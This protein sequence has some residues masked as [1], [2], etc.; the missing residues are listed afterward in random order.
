MG[1]KRT[2][3]CYQPGEEVAVLQPMLLLLA[4]LAA[5]NAAPTAPS[6][7]VVQG[8]PLLVLPGEARRYRGQ[9]GREGDITELLATSEQT[10][11]KLGIF[12]QTI[13][14]GGGPPTH[15]HAM[16]VEFALV[17]SGDFKIRLAGRDRRVPVGTFMFIPNMTAHTFKNVGHSPGVILFGVSGGGFE[18]MFAEREG[19]DAATNK[20]LM[21]KYHMQVVGPPIQ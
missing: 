19:V 21:D 4:Q 1:G 6:N 5:A 15:L 13:A 17:V 10:G 18:K 11:G 2:L 20:K 3:L 12:R 9:Q 8:E 16:E 7:P 14:P